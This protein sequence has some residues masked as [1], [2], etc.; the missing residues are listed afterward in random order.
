MRPA[1]MFI[2]ALERH[3]AAPLAGAA[4]VGHHVEARDAAGIFGFENLDR[5]DV[6]VRQMRRGAGRAIVALS[7]AIG[8]ADDLVLHVRLARATLRPGDEQ[9]RGRARMGIGARRIE[10]R[11][12]LEDH[13]DELQVHLL[14]VRHRRGRRRIGDRLRLED[15]LHAIAHAVVEVQPGPEAADQRIEDAGLDHGGP[16][17]QWPARLRIGVGE[18][19]GR[20]AIL[21]GDGDGELDRLVDV[22]AI[23]VDQPFRTGAAFTSSG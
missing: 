16:Q 23:V 18:V 7:T 15:Q 19:E 1:P 11:H 2:F 13:V 20:E 14:V 22:D 21:D 8:G 4:R 10:L 3:A 9:R 12:G 6:Q 5:R 17:V